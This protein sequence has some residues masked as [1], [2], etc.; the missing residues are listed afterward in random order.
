VSLRSRI[1][2]GLLGVLLTGACAPAHVPRP[3]AAAPAPAPSGSQRALAEALSG[4]IWPLAVEREREVSSTYGVRGVRHHDGLDIRG[5]AGTAIHAAR[6]GRVSYSGWM[7]GYGNIVIL[8]HGSGVTTRY[9]HASELLVRAGERVQRGQTIARVGA[10]GNAT[11]N[12]LH[13]EVRW[14]HHPIDPTRILP[15]MGR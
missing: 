13:F 6:D 8:D 5:G 9:A 15:R 4:M 11:G 10:T 1:A 2:A 12:H 14:G 7:R 3:G